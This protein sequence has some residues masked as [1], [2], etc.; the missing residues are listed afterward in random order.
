M[1]R[2]LGLFARVGAVLLVPMIRV[3]GD[4]AKMVGYPVGLIW[5]WQN[6]H[7]PEVHWRRA[8]WMR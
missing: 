2:P 5:R 7:R 8:E 4:V 3:V 6:R 1:L